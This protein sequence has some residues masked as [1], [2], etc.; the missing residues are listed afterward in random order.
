VRHVDVPG[1]GHDVHKQQPG[2]LDDE[3]RA[4]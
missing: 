2:A 4:L 3:V 1:A